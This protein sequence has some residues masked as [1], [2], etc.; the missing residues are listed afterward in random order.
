MEILISGAST[1]IGKASAVH[2]AGLG[3]SVWAGVRSQKDFDGITDLN[4]SGL[5]PVFLDV[6][7]EASVRECVRLVTKTAGTLDGLVNNAG[8]VVWGPIETVTMADWRRQFEINFFGSVLLTQTCLPLLRKSKG[9][10]IN[11]SSIAG[12]MAFQ[13]MGPY[14]ASKFALEAMSDS[15]RREMYHH[16]VH[17]AV[18]EPG[19]IATPIWE[20]SAELTN[21]LD[22]YSPE[23]R[24]LYGTVVE[25]CFRFMEQT[26]RDAAPVSVVT[27][28]LEHALLS[29]R[30]RTR[31]PVGKGIKPL[32]LLAKVI[33]DRWMDRAVL[34]R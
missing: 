15:L 9:R 17:V 23:L 1:G 14:A 13:F 10:V 20:K 3:H 19:A 29:P 28:A 11:V 16:G 12:R 26:A 31:Y 25:K 18:I 27:K 24:S 2:L 30:P 33:P 8:V 34:G 5:R 4:I 32:T 22:Q 6:T 21:K 7:D